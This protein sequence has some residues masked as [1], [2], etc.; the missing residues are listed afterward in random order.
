MTSAGFTPDWFSRPGDTIATLMA[1]HSLDATALAAG[2][3]RD[4]AFVYRLLAGA[5]PID[6]EL[7]AALAQIVGG[8]PEFWRARQAKFDEDLGRIA[9]ELPPER[10]KS[11]L[12]ILPLKEMADAGWI[13]E[14]KG[15][16]AVRA[17]M[18]YFGVCTAEEWREQYT[19]FANDFSYR[20]SPTYDSKIG[21]LA[22]WLRQGELQATHNRCAAWNARQ[23]RERL[24]AIRLLTKLKEP[25]SF[26]PK[27]RALCA[28]AGVAV[29][30]V[31]AP[32]GC[33]ASGATRF[34]APNKAMIILSFRFLSDDHFW[35]SF[36][37]EAGHLLLHRHDATYIDGDAA[38][39]SQVEREANS[40]A[41]QTLVPPD[42]LDELLQLPPRMRDVVRFAVG[43]G[44]APGIV[45]G[46]LQH[47][48]LLGP[49]QL[50]DLKRRY[51]WDQVLAALG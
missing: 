49:A 31:K 50:N 17:A 19:T 44:I 38:E 16:G 37:H 40:F 10:A 2:L 8:S 46:Q 29:I 3:H 9:S 6:T 47:L 39:E 4:R 15:A 7:A 41:A 24:A 36:F 13:S 22:A 12:K 20:T 33:R 28:E 34:I 43:I 30:F 21:A 26:V 14:R 35:F 32:S 18:S 48:R 51:T 23:F 1:R 27:L 45:V 25:R 11:W 5:E 42:R